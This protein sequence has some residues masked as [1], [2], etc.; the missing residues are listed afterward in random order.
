MAAAVAT[1]LE[2]QFSTIA[3]LEVMTSNSG[4]G[5]TNVTLQ[6]ALERDIDA[7][8]QDVQAAIAQ[9]LRQLPQGILPPSYQKSNPA[10]APILLLALQS[11]LLPLSDL[12]E[13]AQTVLAQRIST[14]KGVAQVNVFGSQ[15]YAV[16]VQLD[17]QA[18]ASRG[19]GIDQVASAIGSG[20]V[21]LPTG[22]LWGPERALTI[23]SEGQLETANEFHS[24]VVS[25]RG[26]APV[27]LG[28]LGEVVDGVEATRAASWFN[29]NRGIVL[30]IQRQ[31]G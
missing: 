22:V 10:D 15:K 28:D 25:T 18:L 13:Y 30:A 21:N 29:G 12:D 3:G 20:N 11:D 6:F 26:G 5:G 2:K 24:L 23:R 8:A 4:L 19:V 27:R 9:T 7:A 31:P 1:P 16:R 17:P 14:V